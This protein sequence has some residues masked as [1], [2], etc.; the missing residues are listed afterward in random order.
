MSKSPII[1]DGH[2][3]KVSQ[4]AY[5]HV[6]TKIGATDRGLTGLP[7]RVESGAFD[8]TVNMTLVCEK[9][10][11]TTLDTSYA[12]VDPTGTPAGNL[13]SFQGVEGITFDPASG[14]DSATHK[15][16]TGVYFTSR[17]EYKPLSVSA[18][19]TQAQAWTVAITLVIN[20]AK[21]DGSA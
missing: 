1:L 12:K 5:G 11:Q 13:L 19:W 21:S 2:V 20:S 9:A 15:Y 3:Y 14:S 7:L 4:L 17:G 8:N 6:S 10:D 18:G 16:N